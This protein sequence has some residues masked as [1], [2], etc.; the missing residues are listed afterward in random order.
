M[1]EGRA[2][3]K[4]SLGSVA[5]LGD[6][7]GGTKQSSKASFLVCGTRFDVDRKYRLIKPIGHG[8]YGVVC[9]AQN[10]ETG[11]MVA[12]KKI[13]KAFANLTETKRTLREAKLL[14]HFQHSNIIRILDIMR[15]DS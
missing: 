5:P 8:A 1:N 4:A 12:I 11:E 6:S 13:T 7:P 15:P 14:R 10:I 2:K 3:D 9:S